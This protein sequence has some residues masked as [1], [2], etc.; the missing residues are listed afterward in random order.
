MAFTGGHQCSIDPSNQTIIELFC[1]LLSTL[2]R[3]SCS[4][5]K[6]ITVIKKHSSSG[7]GSVGRVV[8]SNSR[9]PQ[10]ESSHRQN[11]IKMFYG[12]KDENKEKKSG[13]AH[14]CLKKK[15]SSGVLYLTK[16]VVISLLCH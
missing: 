6:A 10:F 14:F 9:R 3:F 16:Y 2:L 11:L 15:D 4:C 1:S 8:A 13:L 12:R 5:G 7:F